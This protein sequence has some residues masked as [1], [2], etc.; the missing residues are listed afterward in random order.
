MKSEG[1]IL[2]FD[3]FFSKY[4]GIEYKKAVK[5]NLNNLSPS[6]RSSSPQRDDDTDAPSVGNEFSDEVEVFNGE[7]ISAELREGS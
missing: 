4:E 2:P 3:T 5:R 7:K 1:E 6:R